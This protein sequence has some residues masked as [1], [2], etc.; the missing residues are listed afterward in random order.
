MTTRHKYWLH[1]SSTN[2]ATSQVNTAVSPQTARNFGLAVRPSP[3]GRGES[4]KGLRPLKA[5]EQRLPAAS[6]GRFSSA[7]GS[8]QGLRRFTLRQ[9]CLHLRQRLSYMPSPV[10]GTGTRTVPMPRTPRRTQLSPR[11]RLGL[12]GAFMPA[13]VGQHPDR[14]AGEELLDSVEEL[15]AF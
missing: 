15:L 10:G 6:S 8:Q 4:G 11:R 5:G 9:H 14:S 12:T 13:G 1:I 7:R 2:Q 3:V